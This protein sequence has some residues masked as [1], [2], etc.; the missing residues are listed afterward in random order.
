MTRKRKSTERKYASVEGPW[1]LSEG[2]TTIWH[3][4]IWGGDINVVDIVVMVL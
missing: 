4:G 2:L 1:E 3:E